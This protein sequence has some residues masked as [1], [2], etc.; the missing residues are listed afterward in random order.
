VIKC[1][2]TKFYE[3]IRHIMRRKVG[4]AKIDAYHL[5]E[6]LSRGEGKSL[7][8]NFMALGHE[9]EVFFSERGDWEGAFAVEIIEKSMAD[10][11]DS[12]R[13]F[14]ITGEEE[15]LEKYTAGEQSKLPTYFAR[16]RAIVS[17]RSFE[18]EL[19]GKID[20]LEQLGT[21]WT[22]KAAEPE[23][24]AR[25]E[26]NKHPES[27][28]DV[29]ILLE[30]ETG[31][32]IVD[33]IRRELAEFI[34]AENSLMNTRVQQAE[35]AAAITIFLIIVSTIFSVLIALFAALVVSAA[36]VKRLEVLLG[37]TKIV[38]EGKFTQTITIDSQ[39]EIGRLAQSFNNMT[40]TL[41]VSRDEMEKANQDLG[42][43]NEN[44]IIEK[45]R[46]ELATRAKDSFLA[47]ISHEIR[48]PM[49]GVLGMTQILQDTKLNSEQREYVETISFSGNALLDII[50][51]ILDFSKIEAGKLGIE[52]IPFDLLNAVM[53]TTGLF[54]SKCGDKDIEFI[55]SY[56]PD[57]PHHFIGDPGRIRQILMNLIS[58]AIKFTE[59][60]YVF[61]EITSL[62]HNEEE[63]HLS[64]AIVDTGIG[65]SE[66]VQKTLFKPFTQA[67]ASTTRKYGGTGLGLTICKQ[68]VELMGGEIS[69]SSEP[70]KGSTF[71]FDL[72]LP[73]SKEKTVH[74]PVD[75]DFRQLRVLV[76]DENQI[77]LDILS[78]QLSSWKIRAKTVMVGT[79]AIDQLQQASKDKDPFQLVLSG[80]QMPDMSCADLIETIKADPFTENTKFILLTSSLGWRGAGDHFHKL[81]FSGYLGK[82]INLGI[83]YQMI[84][85]LWEHIQ[86]GTEPVGLITRYTISEAHNVNAMDTDIIGSRILL[87]EDN[88]IN[89]KVAKKLLENLGCKVTVAANGQECVEMHRQF[90]YD[91]IFMDCQM[92]VMDGY[93]A[94]KALRASEVGSDKHQVIIA[95]TANAMQGDRKKC[96]DAGMDGIVCKPVKPQ[97]LKAVLDRWIPKQETSLDTMDSSRGNHEIPGASNKP[98]TT[99]DEIQDPPLD[100]A[101]LDELEE[102]SGDDPSF[103]IEVIQQFLQDGPAHM[104]AIRQAVVDDDADA[105]MKAAHGFK[106]MCQYMGALMLSELN[107]TLEQKG[108]AGEAKNLGDFL[109]ELES[110]YS[111]VR[112]ALEA[113]LGKLLP[114]FT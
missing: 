81:G 64:I 110:E 105:L 96:L 7:I 59:T 47:T 45:E 58:N 33:A 57:L 30:K 23:I 89:Q 108:R 32:K 91:I 13:G 11:E 70:G 20:Q 44:L 39:D 82:P 71:R 66:E 104:A 42:K 51:D 31:K 73:L 35:S 9:V 68:L 22:H 48:T 5:Q 76:V 29:V 16:L 54:S 18:N 40:N 34:A 56:A 74:V 84:S 15:F 55:V 78:K 79:R 101:T 67:D 61:L 3:M 46:A 85:L 75:I 94:T 19:M 10:R 60:G 100:A 99:S 69:S 28:M 111:R 63:A 97:E 72:T 50:N 2:P 62:S 102:L 109:T 17:D 83:L 53:E 80:Q 26:M 36:I 112:I 4:K 106:G 93:E 90:S 87:V 49:N 8:D 41:R 37:A 92:P 12:Q 38:S 103:L 98:P 86:N 14:L 113:K 6:I 21:E 27:L 65:I 95:L 24:A 107:F 43:S 114:A 25:R 88:I 1:L 52:P 77:N